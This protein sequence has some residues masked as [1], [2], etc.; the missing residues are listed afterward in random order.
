MAQ[1]NLKKYT[2]KSCYGHL[3]G[4][5]GDLL[6]ERLIDLNWFELRQGAGTVYEITE[7]GA[8]ELTRLGIDLAKVGNLQ[9]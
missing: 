3:G 7:K 2:A 8:V 1:E 9:R 4:K 5:L 6:F